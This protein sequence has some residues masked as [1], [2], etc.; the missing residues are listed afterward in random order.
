MKLVRNLTRWLSS[1]GVEA[2]VAAALCLA[3]L[4]IMMFGTSSGAGAGDNSPLIWETLLSLLFVPIALATIFPLVAASQLIAF[5]LVRRAKRLATRLVLLLISS[6]ALVPYYHFVM[7]ADLTSTSTAS[8]GLMFY[9]IQIA[10]FAVALSLAV[11]WIGKC[12]DVHKTDA[13]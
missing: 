1:W 3:P 6:T 2:W 5:W 10:V 9:P 7:T 11:Y 4:A 12:T 8:L 13:P